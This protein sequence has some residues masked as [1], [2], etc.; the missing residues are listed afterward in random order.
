[1]VRRPPKTPRRRRPGR[2]TPGSA[3]RSRA[4]AAPYGEADHGPGSAR[5]R[6]ERVDMFPE[7]DVSHGGHRS[8]RRSKT[9]E[10]RDETVDA[11]AVPAVGQ[12]AHEPQRG[13]D[14]GRALE[15]VG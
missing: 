14:E 11:V 12:V 3:R 4:S 15:S 8:D 7:C 10:R 13:G 1:M 2:T 6:T 5:P 9:G